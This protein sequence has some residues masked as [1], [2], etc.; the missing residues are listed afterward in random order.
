MDFNFSI[1]YIITISYQSSYCFNLIKDG[2]KK[3]SWSA[4]KDHT[5]ALLPLPPLGWGGEWKEKGK[6]HG[7][8]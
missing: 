2:G 4:T 6:T 7:S 1:Y 8:G 5:V 3:V